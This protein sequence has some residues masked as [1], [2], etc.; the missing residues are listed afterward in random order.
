MPICDLTKTESEKGEGCDRLLGGSKSLI[1]IENPNIA[2]D[3]G[4][5]IFLDSFGSS[6]APF[7]AEADSKITLI[8]TRY[9]PRGWSTG[10]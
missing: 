10:S 4:I 7:L 9:L 2:T 8:D 5:V 3:Q 1:T 6:M